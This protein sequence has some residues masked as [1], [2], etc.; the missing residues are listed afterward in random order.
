MLFGLNRL[1]IL[2]TDI[3]L[4]WH[5]IGYIRDGQYFVS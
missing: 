3:L 1:N 2:Q 4:R 5:R